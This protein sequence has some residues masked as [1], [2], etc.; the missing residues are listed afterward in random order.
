M[1]R[2]DPE[3]RL[4]GSAIGCIC[5]CAMLFG[6]YAAWSFERDLDGAAVF[7]LA[8]G[9]ATSITVGMISG[10]LVERVRTGQW[11]AWLHAMNRGFI[12]IGRWARD[13]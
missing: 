13:R 1:S 12:R 3:A 10:A 7:S 9:I 5:L 4:I 8:M 6:V 11:P 2:G